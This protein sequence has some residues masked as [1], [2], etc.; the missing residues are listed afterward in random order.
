MA[1]WKLYDIC[2]QIRVE[3]IFLY[4]C[5][6]LPTVGIT[7]IKYKWFD[8]VFEIHSATNEVFFLSH[9]SILIRDIKVYDLFTD[10]IY[11][12]LITHIVNCTVHAVSSIEFTIITYNNMT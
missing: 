8:S 2:I 12:I 1:E 6:I 11:V 9:V 7:A 3:S 5:I 4:Y 10:F